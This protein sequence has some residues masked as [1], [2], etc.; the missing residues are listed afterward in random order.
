MVAKKLVAGTLQ[1]YWRVSRGLTLGAQACVLDANNRVLLIRHT[2]RA[3]WH[4]PGGGVERGES[5]SLALAR[6]LK[7]EA[8]V[9]LT[10]EP[11]LFAIYSNARY[12]TGDHI[13][14]Y[15]VRNWRQP[16]VPAANHE[17]A[18]QAFFAH[19]DLPA[20]I[21]PPTRDRITEVLDGRQPAELW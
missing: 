13:A 7:E 2:Y 9:F 15:V 5:V 16:Q 1:R 8:G 12:F 18:E 6:E 14:L 10:A 17:I 3:G 19:A 21:N 20:A 4:F 11:Q